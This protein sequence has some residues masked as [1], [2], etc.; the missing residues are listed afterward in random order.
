VCC[1]VI[2]WHLTTEALDEFLVRP[3]G[4]FGGQNGTGRYVSA[5]LSIPLSSLSDYT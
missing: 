1:H 3:C 4:I 5:Y 2:H